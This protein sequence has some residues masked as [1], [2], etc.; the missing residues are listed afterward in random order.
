[1]ELILRIYGKLSFYTH[2]LHFRPEL[3]M[4][5]SET[6]QVFSLPKFGIYTCST[7]T[8][9]HRG[10]DDWNLH[11]HAQT[12]IQTNRDSNDSFLSAQSQLVA[13]IAENVQQLEPNNECADIQADQPIVLFR[14]LKR[15]EETF[16]ILCHVI[17]VK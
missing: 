6:H 1:M 3:K 9:S 15:T 14:D 5:H 7:P 2:C 11:V 17:F 16:A 8:S 4:T 10:S 12:L 13:A